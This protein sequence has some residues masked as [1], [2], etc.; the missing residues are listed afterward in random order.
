MTN[1]AERRAAGRAPQSRYGTSKGGR[2]ALAPGVLAAVALLAGLGL[3][4]AGTYIV[5]RYIVAI[6]AAIVGVF[7]VQGR[8]WFWLP[9]LAAIVLFWNPVLP[10]SLTGTPWTVVQ[11]VAAGLLVAA[12]VTIRRPDPH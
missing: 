10:F 5:I 8:A 6:L 7:A 1:R 4:T 12:G 3:T 11:V 2:I 9:P